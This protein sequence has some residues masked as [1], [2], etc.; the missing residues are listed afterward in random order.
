MKMELSKIKIIESKNTDYFN[1]VC[2]QANRNFRKLPEPLPWIEPS[3]NMIYM[4]SISSFLFGNYFSSILSMGTLLEHILRLAICD[5]ENTGIN[6]DITIQKLDEVGSI[7]G[8]IEKARIQEII[9]DEDYLWWTKVAKVLRNKS[10][11]FLLPTILKE[12]TKDEYVENEHIRTHYHPDYYKL[13]DKEGNPTGYLSHDWGSFFHKSGYYIAEQFIIDST[14][15]IKKIIQITNW[16]ADRSWW[17][18]QEHYYELIF[19]FNWDLESMKAS[20]EKM[21]TIVGHKR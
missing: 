21:Y 18:S 2:R 9:K 13:T 14:E 3:I 10:A 17:K 12:F 20:L 7:N 5:K 15:K 8:L 4:E 19:N 6:R 1:D 16:E 11:H